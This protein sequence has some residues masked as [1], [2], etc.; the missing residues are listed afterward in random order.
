MNVSQRWLEAF[1]RRPLEL[2]ELTERLTMLGAPV[3]GVEPLHADLADVL[4]AVVEDVRPHPNA[5]RLRVCVVNGGTAERLNVVCGAAN[6]AA[7]QKYPFAP[8]GATL[9]GGLRIERRKLRGET[10]EGMLCSARELGLGQDGEGIWELDT[11]AAPGTR[12]LDALPLADHRLV[13]DVGPNRP[14]LLGHK[15]IA[16]ELSAAYGTPFRL[17]AIPGDSAIDVPPVRRAGASVEVG[18]VHVASEDQDGCPRL[19]GAVMRG[20]K[21]APSPAWLTQR[22]EAVGIRAINNVVDATN[23]VMLELNQPMH[24]YDIARLRGPSVIARRAR[25]GET[26]T[27]L[28][29]IQRTL[30]PEM[31]VIAD[32]AGAIGIAGIMGGAATEVSANTADVFLECAYF[33]PSGVRRSRRTLGLS[34]EASYRFERGI[35]RWGGV[36]AL[37]RCIE[38]IHATAGGELVDAPVD[39]GPGP[40]NPPRIFLRPSRVTQVL[41]IELPWQAVEGYLVSIGAILVPKPEDGR[42]AVEVPSWR[43]DLVREIDLVEEVARLHGY[44]NFPAELRPFRLGRLDDASIERASS[45]VRRGLAGQGLLEVMP[46]PTAPADGAESVPLLNPLSSTEGHLRRRLLPGLIRL[47]QRNWDNHVENVRLFEIGTVFTAARAGQRPGEE[48]HVAAVLTGRRDPPHW[49]ETGDSRIDLWDVKG[50]FEVAVGLAI[51]GGVVQV[52]GNGWIARD[53]HG[54]IVGQ[55]GP[56]EADAPPWASSLFGYEL[57]L[58]QTVRQPPRFMALLSTPSAERVLAL[59]LPDGISVRQVEDLLR[60]SGGPLLEAVAIESDYRGPELPPA[61]RSV[62]FRLT[63]RAPDRTLR[64]SEIDSIETRILAALTAELGIQRRVAGAPGGGE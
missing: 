16:R 27:T 5:D 23:Y 30:S 55:A 9:P 22:L 3:D 42:I 21:I 36:E 8:V 4:I 11:D 52:E 50:Q 49:T 14:D 1:L 17:P 12:L 64:D 33:T 46:L 61:T 35:D 39:V 24:A 58:D 31:T 29:G 19:L 41:G 57:V 45:E 32:A 63:F 6:V 48:R 62:A 34:T 37:R 13:V 15:G 56:L 20:V 28:D 40:A 10:S 60:Q 53:P 43:P 47:V 59:L 25:A 54:R 38:I 18:G 44:Q 7:G 26:V 51:P 2:R